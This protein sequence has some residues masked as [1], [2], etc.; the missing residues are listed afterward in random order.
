ME[1]MAA[2][3]LLGHSY[4]LQSPQTHSLDGFGDSEELQVQL[5]ALLSLPSV[6]GSRQ[7]SFPAP[8]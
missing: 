1:R 3:H 7:L 6:L 8:S 4:K 5:K 2:H